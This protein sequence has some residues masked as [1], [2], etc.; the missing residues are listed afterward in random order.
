LRAENKRIALV[1]EGL[2]ED[3]GRVRFNVFLSQLHGFAATLTKL[4]QDANFGKA[5]SYFRVAE[6]SYSSPAR[7]VLEQQP[8][9]GQPRTDYV[10]VEALHRIADAFAGKRDLYEIDADLL[11]NVRGL[12][13]PVGSKVRT[14]ALMFDD[15]HFD[16]T[17][18]VAQLAHAA[19][20]VEEECE[21]SIEGMLEQI[22]VHLGANTF[23]VYPV[24][25][26]KKVACRFPP[27][28]YDDAVS[29]LGR[30]V[31]VSGTMRYRAR[32][33]HP[34]QVAVKAIEVYPVDRELPDW[35]DLRGRAPEA[36]GTLNSE[37][38]VREL[39]DGWR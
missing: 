26:P 9:P 28:L 14:C 4:D 33:N 11:E 15:A 12:A 34:H 30:R 29:A 20:A 23:H 13:N 31:Q 16:L 21:G 5:A 18:Q 6:L 32:A 3:A 10:V 27:P 37:D 22:N 19:L 38:F 17:A 24:V 1:I 25:G 8:L 7:I 39:R 36:T 2:P 35:E